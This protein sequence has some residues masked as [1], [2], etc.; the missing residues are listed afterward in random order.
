MAGA[1]TAPTITSSSLSGSVA[2]LGWSSVS[3]ASGYIIGYGSS[4]GQYTT[5]ADVGNATSGSVAGLNPTAVDYFAVYAYNA[6]TARSL[7]SADVR[8]APRSTDPSAY[9][10]FAD[11]A[12]IDNEGSPTPVTEPLVESGFAFTSLGNSG[13]TGLLIADNGNGWY[14][15]PIKCLDAEYWG[16]YQSIARTDGAAFDLYSLELLEFQAGSAVITGYDISGGTVTQV[17]N[18]NT[19]TMRL[20]LRCWA[21]PTW[22]RSRSPGGPVSTAAAA[23]TTARLPTWSST[24]FRRL[25]AASRPR[26][27]R[28]SARAPRSW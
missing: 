2:T 25:L 26:P 20:P 6:G 11:Q 7:P 8:L 27:P 1:P 19:S 10:N 14:P 16:T 17:V 15:Y 12:A 3:G 9:V 21:G 24:I 28:S 22:S 13:G 18:L 5:F 23:S 4:A